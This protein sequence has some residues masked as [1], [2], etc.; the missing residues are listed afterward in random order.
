MEIAGASATA[1]RRT[2]AFTPVAA[3]VDQLYRALG[4]KNGKPPRGVNAR[5]EAYLKQ[6]GETKDFGTVLGYF[7]DKPK[8]DLLALYAFYKYL[9]QP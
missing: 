4:Y 8:K 6:H 7:P 3:A 9:H 2:P 5:F 1:A